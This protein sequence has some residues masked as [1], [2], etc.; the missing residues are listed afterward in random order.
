MPVQYSS[1]AERAYLL[2]RDKILKGELPLGTPLSRRKLAAEFGMSFV[3]VSEALQR[4]E[5]E[6]MVESRPRVGTRVRAPGPQDLRNCYIIREALESQAARLFSEKASSAERNELLAMADRLEQMIQADAGQEIERERQFPIQAMHL[7]FHM[8]IVECTGCTV[9]ADL[10]EK[11]HLLTFNW[12]YDVAAGS[13]LASGRHRSL[14]EVIVGYDP[15]AAM[16]AMGRHV[17]N[18]LGEI[19]AGITGR[20]GVLLAG[21][22]QEAKRQSRLPWRLRNSPANR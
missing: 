7:D 4:L 14:A 19:E 5:S 9:L 15:D 12:F 2:I 6:G 17:R 18:G 13:R 11:N 10:V 8:R 1:L 3:P 21:I 16:L 22:A 20:F